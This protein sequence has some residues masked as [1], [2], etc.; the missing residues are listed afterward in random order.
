MRPSSCAGVP[1]PGYSAPGPQPKSL[2]EFTGQAVCY[3][4]KQA[5]PQP[6][7]KVRLSELNGAHTLVAFTNQRAFSWPVNE[8][9]RLDTAGLHCGEHG[10]AR[11]EIASM[12]PARVHGNWHNGPKPDVV[13]MSGSR[14]EIEA[15]ITRLQEA[16]RGA[17]ER[18]TMSSSAARPLRANESMRA[19]VGSAS[20]RR[21]GGMAVDQ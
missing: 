1:L 18:P 10:S 19:K 20:Q 2:A 13:E 7:A 6:A 11:I 17:G 14:R 9:L 4:R 15:F 16:K 3:L 21:L 12:G 5:R 8:G